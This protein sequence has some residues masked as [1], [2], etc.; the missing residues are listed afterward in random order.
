[1]AYKS[2]EST[3]ENFSKFIRLFQPETKT[4]IRKLERVKIK[5]YRQN[6]SLLFNQTRT[7]THTHTHTHTHIYIYVC[8]CYKKSWAINKADDSGVRRGF[9]PKASSPIT[10][11]AP[12]VSWFLSLCANAIWRFGLFILRFAVVNFLTKIFKLTDMMTRH[13]T[14]RERKK[15]FRKIQRRTQ[16]TSTQ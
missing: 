3:R 9:G 8:V 5:L 2:S 6:V 10:Q 12:A 1:M 11:R 13:Y 7:R 16:C 15:D 4:L 14:E